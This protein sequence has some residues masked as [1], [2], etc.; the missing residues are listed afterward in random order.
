M[1]K[2]EVTR[3]LCPNIKKLD[4]S[5]FNFSFAEQ[6]ELDEGLAAE[7]DKSSAMYFQFQVRIAEAFL[8][9]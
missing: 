4:I 7:Q 3:R 9:G 2:L 6:D 1:D 8:K 5:M